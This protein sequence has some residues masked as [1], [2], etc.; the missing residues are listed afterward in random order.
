MAPLCAFE[1]TFVSMIALKLSP[2]LPV[3]A[4]LHHHS[5]HTVEEIVLLQGL[6]K[7]KLSAAVMVGSNTKCV[8][9]AG[10]L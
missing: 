8:L 5:A 7:L 1:S 2:L 10:L 4:L 6:R 9:S 3:S